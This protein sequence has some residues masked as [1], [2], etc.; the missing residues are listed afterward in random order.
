MTAPV[1]LERSLTNSPSPAAQRRG[2]RP[3]P[4]PF[5]PHQLSPAPSALELRL[6]WGDRLLDTRLLSAKSGGRTSFT[7]GSAPGVDFEMGDRR[8]GGPSI[9]LVELDKTG[10]A[11]L[12]FT[13]RM[14]G[15]LELRQGSAPL[16]LEETLTHGI[17][18]PEGDAYVL[19]LRRGDFA[20]LNLGDVTVEASHRRAPVRAAA[21]FWETLDYAWV[22]ALTVTAFLGAM[23]LIS[24]LNARASGEFFGDD[25]PS[26]QARMTQL[27]IVPARPVPARGS[28]AEA[29]G[30]T[31][32]RP[33]AETP[34]APHAPSA[35]TGRAAP[36]GLP[37]SPDRVRKLLEN[38]FTSRG[39]TAGV[40]DRSGLG[41]EL[42]AAVGKLEGATVAG[43][44][45]PQGLLG[46]ASDG[47]GWGTRAGIGS[48]GFRGGPG[49]GPGS[50]DVNLGVGHHLNMLPAAPS[51]TCDELCVDSL[52]RVE[53]SLDKDLIRQVIHDNRQKMR[54]CYEQALSRSQGLRGKVSVKFVISQDGSVSSSAVAPGSDTH[55]LELEQCV[56]SRVRGLQFPRPR[57]GGTVAVTYPFVFQ[58]AGGR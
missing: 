2:G 5:N 32:P 38:V 29:T 51:I 33:Q 10:D 12:R 17:A 26:A 57:G 23:F 8:L 55:N 46:S 6:W 48:V 21:P 19:P 25:T 9:S 45:G 50:G 44:A 22:N 24:V 52:T 27:L 20:R 15:E 3:G 49:R 11:R 39:A 35:G 41:G 28:T 40:F 54:F 7:V 14:T 34:P 4:P 56:V 58:N 13:R 42:T 16:S 31:T 53:G 43:A 36:K 37:A 18:E 1:Y 30:S 47:R